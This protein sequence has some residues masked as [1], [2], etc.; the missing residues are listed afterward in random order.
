MVEGLM[1]RVDAPKTI[2]PDYISTE[3]TKYL[4]ESFGYGKDKMLVDAFYFDPENKI[5]IGVLEATKERCAGHNG[6]LRGVD[7]IEAAAQT[8]LL[9]DKVLYSEQGKIPVFK[10]IRDFNFLSPVPQES[11]VNIHIDKANDVVKDKI[12]ISTAEIFLGN[13]LVSKG[14]IEGTVVN[15]DFFLKYLERESRKSKQAVTKFPVIY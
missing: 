3:R 6:V 5:G 11:V 13:N 4:L 2:K 9:L 14:L 10:G 15:R 8:R 7:M 12:V 1:E